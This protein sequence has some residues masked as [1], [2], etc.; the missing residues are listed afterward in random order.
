MPK[1]RSLVS[2]ALLAVLLAAL[3]GALAGCSSPASAEG[4]RWEAYGNRGGNSG[5]VAFQAGPD[6]IRVKFH[7]DCIYLYTYASAGEANIERMK[8]LAYAGQGLNGY[9]NRHVRNRYAARER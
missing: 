2:L 9:I 1:S 8:E 3:L 5:V 6:F 7:D 4:P